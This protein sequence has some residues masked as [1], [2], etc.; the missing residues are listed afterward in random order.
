MTCAPSGVWPGCCTPRPRRP[1]ALQRRRA[2]RPSRRRSGTFGPRG[3][4]VRV[5]VARVRQL[6]EEDLSAVVGLFERVYPEQR[7]PSRPNCERY[8]RDI[9][10]A[11]PW[12][13]LGLPSRIAEDDGAAIG[14]SGVLPR[15][16][17]FGT[18]AL[19]V[20]VG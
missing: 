19:K 20:A 12:R 3:S 11:N 16:M 13:D 6:E 10:F 7:W 14:F 1:R 8:F 15:S 2:A 9:L 17:L 4:M 5:G 18:R